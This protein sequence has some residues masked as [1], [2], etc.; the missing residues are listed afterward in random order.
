V[1]ERVSE[2]KKVIFNRGKSDSNGKSVI[3]L[4]V[5]CEKN[6]VLRNFHWKRKKE[7]QQT[8]KKKYLVQKVRKV[9]KKL[10]SSK[11]FF[12]RFLLGLVLLGTPLSGKFFPNLLN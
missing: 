10:F 8:R 7:L 1:F 11:M 12:L 3:F 6:N 5:F 2:F 4:G 9:K